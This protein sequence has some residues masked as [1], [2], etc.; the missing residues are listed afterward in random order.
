MKN[1]WYVVTGGPSTGKTTLLSQIKQQGYGVIPEVAR[2]V[3]DENLAVGVSV[4]KLRSDEKK[5]QELVLERKITIEASL[6]RNT[7]TFFDRGIH[8]T[9]AYLMAH[10][11]AVEPWVEAIVD[12]S[13]YKKVFLLEPLEK[14][15]KD[16]ARTEDADFAKRLHTLLYDAYSNCGIEVII[17]PPLNIK[18][19]VNYI[20]K[21]LNQEGSVL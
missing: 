15:E 9:T 1:N 13:S 7:I 17:V 5:F 8:D 20:L 18:S 12:K 16:Y 14:F 3:I 19:R 21:H 4:A 11:F 10:N 2:S 6:N